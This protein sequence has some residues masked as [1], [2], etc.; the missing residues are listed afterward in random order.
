[1]QNNVS[2]A[3]RRRSNRPHKGLDRLLTNLAPDVE[4]DD[5]SFVDSMETVSDNPG[6]GR[7]ID[8]Y[9]YQR[10]GRYVEK[11]L[12]KTMSKFGLAMQSE[13]IS[14][15]NNDG[16]DVSFS[17]V[18]SITST[19]T[20]SNNPGPGRILDKYF[21]QR[22]GRWVE[23]L[24]VQVAVYWSSVP[25]QRIIPY[26]LQFSNFN[27]GNRGPDFFSLGPLPKNNAYIMRS[28]MRHRR[29]KETLDGMK[30]LIKQA[31]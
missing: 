2:N 18:P 9:I 28:I 10:G 14:D 26:I 29:G 3:H 15:S 20:A 24:S 11:M 30:C 12:G 1:M 25:P 13:T 16:D 19:A 6:T 23:R 17:S 27:D 4:E 22:A 21:F 31:K 7:I 5:I 8:K